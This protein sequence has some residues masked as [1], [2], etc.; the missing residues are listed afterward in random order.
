MKTPI[1]SATRRLGLCAL[2]SVALLS[3]LPAVAKDGL[4]DV[5]IV[6]RDSGQ[7]LPLY[8]HKG[9]LWVAGEPGARY[10]VELTNN[11]RQRLL[12]VVSVDGVNAITGQT[13]SLDQAGYVLN[14]GQRYGVSGWRKSSREIAAF[15]FTNLPDAYAARTDRPDDVGVVG[16][17]VFAERR[18][19]ET[20][21]ALPYGR[22]APQ[23]K[24][25]SN[26]KSYSQ[27]NGGGDASVHSKSHR[28]EGPSAG[29]EAGQELGTGH[30]ERE[31]DRVGTTDFE[32]RQDRPE[33][34]VRIRYDSRANLVAMG[35][36][37]RYQRPIYGHRPSAFP[38]ERFGYVPDPY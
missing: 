20:P 34:I 7:V 14:P 29:L 13:A 18:R 32:R 9:E 17:A 36:I 31:W 8:R 11:T 10:A 30:G 38:A 4:A 1:K 26:S 27:P 35:V 15:E 22:S 2:A 28:S 23:S 24:S 16:V 37:P 19:A 12:H 6:N 21:Q 5:R 3:A 33:Q 25:N